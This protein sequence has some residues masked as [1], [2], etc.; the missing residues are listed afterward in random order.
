M[1]KG[2]S[3]TAQLFISKNTKIE[4]GRREDKFFLN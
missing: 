4:K 3:P 1:I 2:K